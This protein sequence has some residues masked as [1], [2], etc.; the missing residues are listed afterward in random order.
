VRGAFLIPV[1]VPLRSP[2]L[3]EKEAAALRQNCNAWQ[4]EE[5][6]GVS[7]RLLFQ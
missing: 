5:T 1:T 4:L 3:A 7:N 2:L 6:T